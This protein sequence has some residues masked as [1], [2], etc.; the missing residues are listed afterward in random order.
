MYIIHILY[1][2]YITHILYYVICILHTYYIILHVCDNYQDSTKTRKE[3]L[4]ETRLTRIAEGE[5]TSERTNGVQSPRSL[6]SV[7]LMVRP[8]NEAP[9]YLTG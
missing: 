2:M 6:K 7:N 8:V 9:G 4:K 5:R 1:Y 3:P